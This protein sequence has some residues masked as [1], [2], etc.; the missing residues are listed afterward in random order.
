MKTAFATKNQMPFFSI[1]GHKSG[2][3]VQIDENV[4]YD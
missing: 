4:V 2:V 3:Y 1:V